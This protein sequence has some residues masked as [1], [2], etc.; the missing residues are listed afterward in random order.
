MDSYTP[1]LF[2]TFFFFF[3][4]SSR[5]RHTRSPGD[6]SSD[7]CSSDL[8]AFAVQHLL[9]RT[10][11]EAELVD[12]R[13]GRAIPCNESAEGEIALFNATDK[14]VGVGAVDRTAGR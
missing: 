6:W 13:C 5:R 12:V 1:G 3:F 7:V 9:S 4:F 11:S 10:L 8:P 14:L 2:F